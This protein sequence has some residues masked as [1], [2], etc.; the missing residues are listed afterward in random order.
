MTFNLD[1]NP[2]FA[3]DATAQIVQGFLKRIFKHTVLTTSTGQLRSILLAL[4]NSGRYPLD[5]QST[6]TQ[7]EEDFNDSMTLILEL[8]RKSREPHTFL[9]EGVSIFSKILP[10]WGNLS[11]NQRPVHSPRPQQELLRSAMAELSMTR[12]EFSARLGCARRTLDKW[13]LPSE[14]QDSRNIDETIYVLVEE[15]LRFERSAKSRI[16][17]LV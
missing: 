14:S 12:D 10:G 16:G 13:L 9:V 5:I 17:S 1:L 8:G 3:S 2:E 11:R 7:S 4:Y 15:V 6:C